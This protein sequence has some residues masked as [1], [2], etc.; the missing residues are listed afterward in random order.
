MKSPDITVAVATYNREAELV[1]TIKALLDQS[2]ENFELLVLDQSDTHTAATSSA[3]NSIKD[4]RFKYVRLAPPSLMA[5]RNVALKMANA[6]IILFLDD[7]IEPKKDLV[8][9]HLASFRL[10]P[11]ISAVAGRVTQKGFPADGPILS[12]DK[13]AVS[14]G[15]FSSKKS[16]YTNAF[17]GGNHSIRVADSLAVGGYDTRYYRIAFREENDMSAKL[18][19]AGKKIFYNPRA[20]IY[21]LN[22]ASG[23]HKHY[24]DLFDNVDFYRNEI[25]FTM[26]SVKLVDLPRALY[27]KFMTYCHIRPLSKGFKRS[28]FFGIG[29]LTAVWRLVF[30]RQIKSHR[31]QS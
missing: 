26:R 21:H 4:A 8:K 17:A 31:V 27:I 12:F 23:G 28:L 19:K 6:P 30:G 16:G 15:T 1:N 25:F 2:Y 7:D 22:T 3:L 24:I 20:E 11:E 5:A 13:Y 14:H 10:H 9:E 29:I 18:T